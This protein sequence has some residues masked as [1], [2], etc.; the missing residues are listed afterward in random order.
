MRALIRIFT[1]FEMTRSQKNFAL[2]KSGGDHGPPT[3][4]F[5]GH[6]IAYAFE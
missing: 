2:Q 4:C 5:A 1:V 3:P 6:A